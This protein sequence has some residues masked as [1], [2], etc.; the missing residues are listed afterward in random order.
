MLAKVLESSESICRNVLCFALNMFEFNDLGNDWQNGGNAKRYNDVIVL[1]HYA[2]LE[3]K[4]LHVHSHGA[5]L[6]G[7]IN[8]P[9]CILIVYLT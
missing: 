7:V 1:V 5:T 9:L 4:L 8:I 6:C 2:I 3:E